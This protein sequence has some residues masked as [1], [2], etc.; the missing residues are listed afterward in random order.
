MNLTLGSRTALCH[1][2]GHQASVMGKPKDK[3]F[4]GLGTEELRGVCFGR[5]PGSIMRPETVD[6]SSPSPRQ[7]CL[8]RGLSVY[9]GVPQV[10]EGARGAGT[11]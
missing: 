7:A 6:T 2:Q 5:M 11:P 4:L 3:C 1:V 8:R 9:Q 10:T